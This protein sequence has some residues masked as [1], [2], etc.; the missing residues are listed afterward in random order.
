[1]FRCAV[2]RDTLAFTLRQAFPPSVR[3]T[4]LIQRSFHSKFN[5]KVW[6]VKDQTLRREPISITSQRDLSNRSDSQFQGQKPKAGKIGAALAAGSIL[7][8]KTK[9][10]LVAMKLT[11]MAPLVSMVMTSFA[12][13][14]FFGWPYSIGMVGLV[15]V[16][17]CGH[18]IC[19]RHYK[20]P[21]SPMV[22]V[23]D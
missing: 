12:Y 19:M 20:V 23:C 4:A 18:V 13:S 8:G 10:V 17:E 11:K 3:A 15:F 6:L 5:R 2:H 1:M 9:Y 7:L 21:F 16:H 22:F 14:F